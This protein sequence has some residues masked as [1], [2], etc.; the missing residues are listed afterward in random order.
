MKCRKIPLTIFLLTKFIFISAS[1]EFSPI[2]PKS[3]ENE[4]KE[5]QNVNTIPEHSDV[6]EGESHY[7][8]YSFKFKLVVISGSYIN[9]DISFS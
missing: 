4:D 5:N 9:I 8:H 3:K 6:N 2:L 1:P 7:L